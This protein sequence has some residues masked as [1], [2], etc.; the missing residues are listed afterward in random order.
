MWDFYDR[1]KL[2]EEIKTKDQLIE[3]QS[4]LLG[5]QALQIDRLK[6]EVER[7]QKLPTFMPGLNT[8]NVSQSSGFYHMVGDTVHEGY[9]KDCT[10]CHLNKE[11]E[12]WCCDMAKKAQGKYK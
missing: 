8:R 12:E 6:Q 1:E 5:H 2:L 7:L 11:V 3:D 9:F 4:Y 10:I